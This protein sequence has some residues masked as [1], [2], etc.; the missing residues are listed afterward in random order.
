MERKNWIN[1]I[2]Y[3]VLFGTVVSCSGT[4]DDV[5]EYRIVPLPQQ[6]TPLGS[7]AFNLNAETVI[8]CD[9]IQ[10]ER[11]YAVSYLAEFLQKHL[12][13][14]LKIS[15]SC[16][17]S[18]YI[19]LTQHPTDKIN[20]GY[21]I[22]VTDEHIVIEGN[23]AAGTFYGVQT[24]CKAAFAEK[25]K[26]GNIQ[27]SAVQINDAPAFS[28]RGAMLDVCRHFYPL[29]FVKRYIDILALHNI[30]YF[31]WH[32]TDDQG[33]RIDIK[34]YPELTRTGAWRKQT[35]VGMSED[36]FDAT[37]HGGF[38]TQDEIKEVVE[39]AQQKFITVVPEIDLPGHTLAM[40]ASY[41]ELG[42]KGRD[43]KVSEKWGVFEDVLCA[44]NEKVYSFLEGVFDEI[45]PLFPGEYIHVGGDE[46]PKTRWKEC[47]ICQ[48]KINELGLKSDSL[49]TAE[50]K[51]Q[52]YFI[53]RIGKYLESKGK[54]VIGWDE[55]L[56]GGASTETTIMSWRGTEGGIRAAA[57]HHDVIMSPNTS[58]YFDYYPTTETDSF[59]YAYPGCNPLERV[60]MYNPMEKIAEEDR[61]YLKG[62]QA[63]LWTEFISDSSWVERMVMPRMGGLAEVQW[64]G[65]G[66]KDYKDFLT[67]LYNF[68]KMYKA[69][70]YKFDT[71]DFDV[72]PSF[73]TD[74]VNKCIEVKLET[75]DSLPIYYT[76]DGKNPDETS[77]LYKEP[78][79]LTSSA[80]LRAKGL[81]DKRTTALYAKNVEFNK[82][83]ASPI[84]LITPLVPDHSVGFDCNA[85]VDGRFG[86]K[87]LYGGG[88]W[89]IFFKDFV[90]V[91]DLKNSTDVSEVVLGML[92][93][94]YK[95]VVT[96]SISASM[97][98]KNFETLKQQETEVNGF[99]RLKL[100]FPKTTA[101]YVKVEV[102]SQSPAGI[103]CDELQVY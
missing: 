40:L 78:I 72:I 91:V 77:M 35:V 61:K 30:N 10:S 20:D 86:N 7:N 43:Y 73:S 89:G 32:L 16:P 17:E 47:A 88:S 56:N 27:L 71:T 69:L 48:K 57:A 103:V 25:M 44:G 84:T 95:G 96:Y 58:L 34:K 46:C 18:N 50:D 63:N 76:L 19:Y 80:K 62:V 51:L 49:A 59:P 29:S 94:P 11:K 90:A 87:A 53:N 83:T 22:E 38:Y 41:P 102:H 93:V 26:D 67:R 24:L 37:P 55:V 100:N 33:W 6:V 64:T 99:C 79:K 1:H 92:R 12:G 15:N 4:A 101:R 97:D 39:Y 98:N 3:A 75:F 23:D 82:A 65:N 66:N 36:E 85:L 9:T 54:K 45:I 42:C 14:D 52:G 31:H 70:D 60:Y 74:T 8:V 68:S 21:H 2:F 5:S 13:L 28:Y 81:S